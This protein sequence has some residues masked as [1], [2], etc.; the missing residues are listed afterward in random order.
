M[1]LVKRSKLKKKTAIR[2]II[3][4]REHRTYLHYSLFIY[5]LNSNSLIF[6]SLALS[7]SLSVTTLFPLKMDYNFEEFVLLLCFNDNNKKV[8]VEINQ[9]ANMT[10]K[11]KKM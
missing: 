11:Q 4:N 7:L 9:F 10:S 3:Y 2:D 5:D 6:D 1:C 8:L